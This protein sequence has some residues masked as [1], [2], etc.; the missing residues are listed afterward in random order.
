MPFTDEKIAALYPSHGAFV[1]TFALA[2]LRAY[3]SGYLTEPDVLNLVLA[4]VQSD[5]GT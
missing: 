3:E 5:I 4:A 2:S 1:W